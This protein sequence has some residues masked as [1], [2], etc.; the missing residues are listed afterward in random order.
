MAS[1]GVLITAC[2]VALPA[3]ANQRLC[4]GFH[5]LP[6]ETA[7]IFILGLMEGRVYS[8][9]F[10]ER[11]A[12]TQIDPAAKRAI[13]AA[14][15]KLLRV[16]YIKGE[17]ITTPFYMDVALRLQAECAKPENESRKVFE[18]W[19]ADVEARRQ[20][21]TLPPGCVE[22]RRLASSGPTSTSMEVE[23]QSV[24]ASPAPGS[25]RR[26]AVLDGRSE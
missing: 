23:S 7:R 21:E 26:K 25:P 3:A 22:G 18:I 14:H 8:A 15:Q 19:E 17:D 5:S 1:L 20:A 12:D 24:V 4:Y 11:L 2:A 10:L 9:T 16:D 6:A 13:T